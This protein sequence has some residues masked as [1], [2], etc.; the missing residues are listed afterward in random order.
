MIT[1]MM[2][3][4]NKVT[5]PLQLDLMSVAPFSLRACSFIIII[6]LAIFLHFCFVFDVNVNGHSH[7]YCHDQGGWCYLIDCGTIIVIPIINHMIITMMAPDRL[8]PDCKCFHLLQQLWRCRYF[9]WSGCPGGSVECVISISLH[10]II[11]HYLWWSM[12]ID[13]VTSF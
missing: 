4:L 10:N 6:S 1:T 3:N 5:I 2:M 9:Q 8:W 7:H 11:I 12:I 13:F